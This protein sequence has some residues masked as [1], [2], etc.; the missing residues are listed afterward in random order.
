ML[1]LTKNV[2]KQVPV[3]VPYIEKV[4]YEVQ[5]QYT[6]SVPYQD[7][8]A[9]TDYETY[10]EQEYICRNTT[11]RQCG[12][13]QE[14]GTVND[15]QCRTEQ[16]CDRQPGEVTCETVRECEPD[17]APVCRTERVCSSTPGQQVC[18][19]V[20]EC[21]TNA[22][23]QR[24]CKTRQ[25]C[26]QTGGGQSCENVERCSGG[27][28]GQ[29]RDRRVCRN[30]EPTVS[31]RNENRCTNVPRQVCENRNVCRDVPDQV[32][33]YENVARQRAVTRYRTVTRYRDEVRTRTVTKYQDVQKCCRTEM[34]SEFDKQVTIPVQVLL[35]QEAQLDVNETETFKVFIG[36]NETDIRI[37]FLQT[38]Y[39]YKVEKTED[40]NGIKVITLALAP[41]IDSAELGADKISAINLEITSNSKRVLVRDLVV[42]KRIQSQYSAQVLD[43]QTQ[44]VVASGVANASPDGQ[45]RIQL[46][47]SEPSSLVVTK[48]YK[49]KLDVVR[50]SVLIKEPL[51]FSKLADYVFEKLN[52]VQFG[53][54]TVGSPSAKVVNGN[55]VISF[56]DKGA[57]PR[58]TTQYAFKFTGAKNGQVYTNTFDSSS[59]VDATQTANIVIPM[60]L[61]GDQDGSVEVRLTRFG[62]ALSE[63]VEFSLGT[64]LLK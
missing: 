49:I 10:Y 7:Q 27:S 2:F 47:E 56:T 62:M 36:A 31:C 13:V 61:L 24:I 11:R 45:V 50:S 33:G 1:N 14:C 57:D 22:L 40:V 42:N 25:V 17:S 44:R 19:N 4:P 30:G 32:C 38:I 58:F 23:G 35:P 20:E 18:E 37:D 55:A 29:C 21:G 5:E 63:T 43:V 12:M 34:K 39:G 28:S 51:R 9:Y 54:L 8:E 41:K 15:Q 52:A 46:N 60:Q 53:V 26:R 59:V 6:V 3:Q 16:V 64:Y 48:I